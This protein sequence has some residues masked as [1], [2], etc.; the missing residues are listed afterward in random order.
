MERCYS[1]T[2]SKIRPYSTYMDLIPTLPLD[3]S[4]RYE[5]GRSPHDALS[6]LVFTDYCLKAGSDFLAEVAA[7]G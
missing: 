3:D 2:L 6:V 7:S 4:V 5:K 1:F